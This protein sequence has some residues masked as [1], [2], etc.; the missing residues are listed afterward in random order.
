MNITILVCVH[1]GIRVYAV[2]TRLMYVYQAHVKTVPVYRRRLIYGNVSVGLV[3]RDLYVMWILMSA[4]LILVLVV[5][6]LLPFQICICA[7]VR[8][9][10][11][12]STANS[13]MNH[14][15]V[16]HATTTA[17]A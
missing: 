12:V 4:R 7:H 9:V 15:S 16:N 5:D 11:L 14:A 2:S 17:S 1:Q 3:I 6:A 8:Q 10:I 13:N